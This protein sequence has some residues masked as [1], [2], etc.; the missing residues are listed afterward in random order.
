VTRRVGEHC[1][2]VFYRSFAGFVPH[3]LCV[4]RGRRELCLVLIAVI[5]T[6]ICEALGVLY[7]T[8]SARVNAL[9]KS[10]Q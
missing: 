10:L 5:L 8:L 2:K 3:A 9:N 1:S 7:V 6:A 4:A